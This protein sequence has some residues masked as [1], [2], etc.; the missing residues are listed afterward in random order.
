MSFD[1]EVFSEDNFKPL[2]ESGEELHGYSYG[3]QEKLFKAN[4]FAVG[5]TDRRLIL[6]PL[7]T[8]GKPQGEPIML[9]PEELGSAWM[10]A[11]SGGGAGPTAA[12]MHATSI[13][14][15]LESRDGSKRKL[16]MMKGASAGPFAKYRGGPAQEQ[17]VNAL[18]AFLE[19]HA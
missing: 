7:S 13:T 1:P 17:G 9:R 4:I 5:V 12:I 8:K 11:G 16:M 10:R 15:G 19:Q 3:N 6:L 14:V 2:L 18:I